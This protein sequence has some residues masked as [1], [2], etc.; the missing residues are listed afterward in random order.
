MR[1][2]ISGSKGAPGTRPGPN[3]FIFMLLS[4]TNVQNNST[5]GVVATPQEKRGAATAQLHLLSVINIC[6]FFLC[7]KSEH[8]SFSHPI[9][10]RF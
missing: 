1:Y 6:Q 8:T 7:Q 4:A 2:T 10:C 5:L 9:S 3:S